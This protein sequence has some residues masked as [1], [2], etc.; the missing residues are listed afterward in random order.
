M[1]R[2]IIASKT[3]DKSTAGEFVTIQN[4]HDGFLFK[5]KWSHLKSQLVTSL[6]GSVYVN[7]NSN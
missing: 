2:A 5:F 3:T 4:L 7:S 1:F 6:F